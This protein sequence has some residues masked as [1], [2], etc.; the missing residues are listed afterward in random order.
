[1]NYDIIRTLNDRIFSTTNE[2]GEVVSCTAFRD[3]FVDDW[4]NLVM[5]NRRFRL[6]QTRSQDY[7]TDALLARTVI[8]PKMRDLVDEGTDARVIST[9]FEDLTTDISRMA[10]ER[11][12][13]YCLTNSVNR[14]YSITKLRWLL[15][16]LAFPLFV[17]TLAL[18]SLIYPLTIKWL[19][20]G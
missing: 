16:D 17:A 20:P 13:V 14:S 8:I 7:S 4:I 11:S 3:G 9:A 5:R 12:A 19:L 6:G 2:I 15:L 18:V 1:M 10:D